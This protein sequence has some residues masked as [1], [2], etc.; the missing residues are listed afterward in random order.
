MTMP[1]PKT[2]LAALAKPTNSRLQSWRRWLLTPKTDMIFDYDTKLEGH[3]NGMILMA[4]DAQGDVTLRE[5]FYSI[6]GGF[7]MTEAELAAGK[8][9][10]KARLCPT[11]SN[12]PPKCWRCAN[13]SGKS[14]AE[15]KRA[16]EESRGVLH[17]SE[18]RHSPSVASDERLYQSR[19]GNRRHFAGRL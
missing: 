6:G 9:P 1:K 12:P 10:M 19:A 8:T 2:V 13:A 16:N 14:I 5:T 15:M 18:K 7:V 17:K 3:A 4:T 11:L